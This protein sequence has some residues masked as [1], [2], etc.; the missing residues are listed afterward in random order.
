MRGSQGTRRGGRYEHQNMRIWQPRRDGSCPGASQ[1]PPSPRSLPYSDDIFTP[2]SLSLSH[3][4]S[5][6]S[7]SPLLL[8]LLTCARR[9]SRCSPSTLRLSSIQA[10]TRNHNKVTAAHPARC[11]PTANTTT[12]IPTSIVIRCATKLNKKAYLLSALLCAATTCHW[13]RGGQTT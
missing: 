2:T 5:W 7:T 8:S 12:T 3:S 11:A 13:L 1:R 4:L 10:P 6:P 9:V